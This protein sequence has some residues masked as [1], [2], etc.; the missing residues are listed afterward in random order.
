MLSIVV[1]SQCGYL[2][3]EYGKNLKF[4]LILAI[5]NLNWK[6]SHT[7]QS[8]ENFSECLKQPGYVNLLF[9]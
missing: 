4:F 8:L 9:E 2:V 7:V 3:L 5:L 1:T 6:N